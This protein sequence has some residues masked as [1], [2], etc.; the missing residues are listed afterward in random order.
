M[1]SCVS[2]NTC[3]IPAA[4]AGI[5]VIQ[6]N[7]RPLIIY[8]FLYITLT[9]R[10]EVICFPLVFKIQRFC[11]KFWILRNLWY[12]YKKDKQTN[13]RKIMHSKSNLETNAQTQPGG[14]NHETIHCYQLIDVQNQG[15]LSYVIIYGGNKQRAIKNSTKIS[16]FAFCVDTS[17]PIM[18][19]RYHQSLVS[20]IVCHTAQW[21]YVTSKWRTVLCSIQ[22]S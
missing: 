3:F 14:I 10:I 11:F 5:I 6:R 2:I 21:L 1:R 13:K 8:L 15:L 19:I 4:N 18:N 22:S 20:R 7:C 12:H 16:V 9:F 17:V